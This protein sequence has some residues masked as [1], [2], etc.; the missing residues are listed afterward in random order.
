MLSIL[1]SKI[2]FNKHL[3]ISFTYIIFSS[4]LIVHDGEN[5]YSFGDL[6]QSTHNLIHIFNGYD[7]NYLGGYDSKGFN[8]PANIILL[9][10]D[11]KFQI[12]IKYFNTTLFSICS[13]ISFLYLTKSLKIFKQHNCYALSILYS[14]N[15]LTVYDFSV[16][17]VLKASY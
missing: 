4:L 10:F 14:I 11:Y 17:L 8:L 7:W 5:F 1:H 9:F 13:F 3:I 6:N 16:I 15:P 2:T 12:F